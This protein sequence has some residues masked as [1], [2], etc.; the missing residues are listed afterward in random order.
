MN[1]DW[2]YPLLGGVLIGLS[3][4]LMLYFN[5]RVTGISGIMYN[6]FPLKQ[7]SYWRLFFVFGLL[8]AGFVYRL[9]DTAAL[10]EQESYFKLNE[11][12]AAAQTILAGLLVGFGTVLGS[13]CTSGHGICGLSRFSKRSLL[14]TL[15]FILAGATTVFIL[16]KLFS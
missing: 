3:A 8:S 1:T 11:N 7:G 5:G 12:L 10:Q 13:G 14:A 2:L 6:L 9:F 16:R 4:S 15:T